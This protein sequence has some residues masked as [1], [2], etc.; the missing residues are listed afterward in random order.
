MYRVIRH[1]PTGSTVHSL[2]EEF[3]F[4]GAL[5]GIFLRSFRPFWAILLLSIL[6]SA[7]HFLQPP[8]DIALFV[9]PDGPIPDGQEHRDGRRRSRRSTVPYPPQAVHLDCDPESRIGGMHE[10]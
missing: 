1:P 7:L 10:E 9:K 6:F 4:R 3:I 2:I 5:L 8:D